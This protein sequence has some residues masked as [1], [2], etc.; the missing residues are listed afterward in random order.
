MKFRQGFGR[1]MRRQDDFGVVMVPDKRIVTKAY[2]S[3]FLSSLPPA[4]RVVGTSRQVMDG[5]A[6]F[7]ARQRL[8]RPAP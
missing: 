5:L 4:G 6:E 7:L 1:L 8:G 2:G 3:L